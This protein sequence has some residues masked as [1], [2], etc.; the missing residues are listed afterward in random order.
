MPG[1]G[2]TFSLA[3]LIKIMADLELQVLVT[4]FTHSAL[5]NII[6][7][8]TEMFGND[9]VESNIVRFGINSKNS[10]HTSNHPLIYDISNFN[11]KIEIETFFHHKKIHFITSLGLNVNI[12]NRFSYDHCIMDEASQCLET[13]AL[14]PLNISNKFTLVGDHL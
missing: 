9:F 1:T 3:I 2:K 8:I 13:L 14:G 5:D 12:L 4:S 10:I 11:K 7:K 6:I